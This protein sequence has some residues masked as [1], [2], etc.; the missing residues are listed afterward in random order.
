[1]QTR[2]AAPRARP[3]SHDI[4]LVCKISRQQYNAVSF[5]LIRNVKQRRHGAQTHPHHTFLQQQDTHTND[6]PA[7]PST[8]TYIHALSIHHA[9]IYLAHAPAGPQQPQQLGAGLQEGPLKREQ[10]AAAAAQENPGNPIPACLA[11]WRPGGRRVLVLVRLRRPATGSGWP[12]AGQGGQQLRGQRG[13]V[14]GTRVRGDLC[15]C[16]CGCK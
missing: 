12:S 8:H 11:P 7:A 14:C 13:F 6:K 15:V 4:P 16:E 1:M 2:E 10:P 3:V 9:Y 5:F